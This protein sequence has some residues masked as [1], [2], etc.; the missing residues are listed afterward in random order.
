[1]KLLIQLLAVARG[2]VLSREMGAIE[3]EVA[4]LSVLDRRVLANLALRELAQASK[5]EHPHLYG[6]QATE[7]YRPWGTGTSVAMERVRSDNSQIKLRGIA[8]WL[9]IAFHET[10]DAEFAGLKDFHRRV[11]KMMRQLKESLGNQKADAAQQ[12]FAQAA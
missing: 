2:M 4:G 6:S 1:M 7:R 3:R 9:A 11:L 10:K 12:W 8:L 5:T